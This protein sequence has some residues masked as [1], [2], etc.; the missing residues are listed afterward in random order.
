MD[1]EK[2][3]QIMDLYKHYHKKLEFVK[4]SIIIQERKN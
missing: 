3:Q 1:K 2:L 4:F